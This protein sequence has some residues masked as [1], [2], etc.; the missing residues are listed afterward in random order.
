MPGA[1]GGCACRGEP[2]HG[3]KQFGQELY[4]VVQGPPSSHRRTPPQTTAATA[5]PL[6]P[7]FMAEHG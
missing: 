7:V 2:G 4:E 3:V 5:F 6:E 1:V